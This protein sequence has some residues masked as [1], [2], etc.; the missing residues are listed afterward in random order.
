MASAAETRLAALFTVIE[1]ISGP[2]AERNLVLPEDVPDGGLLILR[3]GDPGEPEIAMSP[4]SYHYAHA[5]ELEIFVQGSTNDAAFDALKVAVG[6]AI[7]AD[8]TLGGLCDWV[9]AGAPAPSELPSPGTYPVK[10]AVITVTLSYATSDP[11]A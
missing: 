6:T 4:L 11:L 8:R 7:A 2:A 3:D 9:E 5:A 10:A 1:A